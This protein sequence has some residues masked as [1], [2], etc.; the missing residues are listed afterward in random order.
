MNCAHIIVHCDIYIYLK[1]EITG[2]RKK[3]D[4]P[5]CFFLLFI[6]LLIISPLK[7]SERKK[8]EKC[9][10]IFFSSTSRDQCTVNHSIVFFCIFVC[11]CFIGNQQQQPKQSEWKVVI[12]DKDCC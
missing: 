7:V 8:N 1:E 4:N 2:L 11:V 9:K 10:E 3:T 5:I 12:Q 6:S